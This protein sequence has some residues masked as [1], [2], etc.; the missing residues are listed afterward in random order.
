MNIDWV[1]LLI[2]LAV[3][4]FFGGTI[5]GAFSGLRAKAAG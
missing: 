2:G 1:W 5:R 4:M 3:G